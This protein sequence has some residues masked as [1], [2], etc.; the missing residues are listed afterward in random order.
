MMLFFLIRK[1]NSATAGCRCGKYLLILND[2]VLL[3]LFTFGT[4]EIKREYDY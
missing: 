3:R 2:F 4:T 1:R